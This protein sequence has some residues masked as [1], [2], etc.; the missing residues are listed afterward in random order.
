M[1]E[2]CTSKGEEKKMGEH[3][4]RTIF[5]SDVAA[6]ITSVFSFPQ[7]DDGGSAVS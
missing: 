4:T 6:V 7:D 3:D 2:S 5:H 1:K